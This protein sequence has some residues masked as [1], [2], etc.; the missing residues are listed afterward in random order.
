MSPTSQKLLRLAGPPVILLSL[1]ICG[2]LLSTHL[3]GQSAPTTPLTGNPNV[4]AIIPVSVDP[5]GTCV[6]NGTSGAL[7]FSTQN[8]TT[9]LRSYCVGALGSQTWA[10]DGIKTAGFAPGTAG[11]NLVPSTAGPLSLNSVQIVDS[12]GALNSNVSGES[13]MYAAY[14]NITLAQLNAGFQAVPDVAS[15][16][17]KVLNEQF[18]A[19]GAAPAACTAIGV[20]DSS[21]VVAA[22][23]TIAA[24]S[25]AGVQV[26]T[27][28][29]PAAGAWTFTTFETGLT[30]GKGLKVVQTGSACTTMTSMNFKVL[31]TVQ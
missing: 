17:L 7:Y 20:T 15:R 12:T 29:A 2:M 28:T 25:G 16:T 14:G 30:A 13:P 23:V 10:T 22:T 11:I 1:A 5:T 31:Y 9:G 27:E 26:T 19:V 8:I 6:M 21:A 4:P 3:A 18:S 24:L